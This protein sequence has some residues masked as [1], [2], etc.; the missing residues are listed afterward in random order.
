MLVEHYATQE[1]AE[2]LVS[3]GA[4]SQLQK[5]IAPVSAAHNFA[6]PEKDVTVF[7]A[8]D[9]SEELKV[10]KFDNIEMYRLTNDWQ[11]YD[12]IFREGEWQLWGDKSGRSVATLLEEEETEEN[13]G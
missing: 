5:R 7:Y 8:R 9:R 10:N 6:H 13:D 11:E 12:Y 2:A 1:L 4:I 3:G